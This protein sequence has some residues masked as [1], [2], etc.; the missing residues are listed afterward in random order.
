MYSIKLLRYKLDRT[1]EK[2]LPHYLPYS[3]TLKGPGQLSRYSDS[4]RAGRSGD[5]IPVGA[6]LSAPVQTGTG[7]HPATYTMGNG[8][9][10]RG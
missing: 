6:R 10:S 2:F 9:L 4:L 1:Y 8:S 7:A 5:R 3:I